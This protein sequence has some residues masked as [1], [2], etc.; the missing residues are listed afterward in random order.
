MS[1][2]QWLQ[3]GSLL[4]HEPTLAGIRQHFEVVDRDLA[5]AAVTGLS[6]DCRFNLA[7]NAGLQLCAIALH[8]NGFKA[9]KG[10]GHHFTT[11]NALDL[12]VGDS[13]KDTKVYLS[14]CNRLRSQG[15]Y[16]R[17]GV[18]QETDAVELLATIKTLRR[19]VQEWLQ[20]SH[21][22]LC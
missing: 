19:D 13:L 18:V 12:C 8:A 15:I 9:A 10:G 6:S 3:T 17:V 2:E 5:D 14:R 22:D 11:I 21:P 4:R 1:L 20:K 16:D 7:Y